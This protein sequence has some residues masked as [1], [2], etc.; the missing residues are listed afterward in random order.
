MAGARPNNTGKL[1]S[2][3]M[4]LLYNMCRWVNT[5][6]LWLP[7]RMYRPDINLVRDQLARGLNRTTVF[8]KGEPL[9]VQRHNPDAP[10]TYFVQRAE[11]RIVGASR[12]GGG[13][14]LFAV[15]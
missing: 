13:P 2:P 10:C 15:R 7:I 3:F 1:I 14:A 11:G 12:G 5:P 8:T 9:Y 4:I 6:L